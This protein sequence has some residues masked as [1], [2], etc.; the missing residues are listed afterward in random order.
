[1]TDSRHLRALI[2]DDEP[3]ARRG[4]RV[5][6]VL[7][8]GF[9]IVGE[10]ASGRA[11]V[12][13][14]RRLS[15][16]VV[17]LDVQMPE[18]S[19]FDVVE[20]VGLGQMPITVFITAYD[21][22]ALRAFEAHAVDYL[23]KPIDP[24]RFRHTAERVRELAKTGHTPQRLILRDGSRVVVLGLEQI[25]WVEADGD[26]V[27]VY[28]G[29]RGHLVRHTIGALEKRL[30]ATQ[31]VRIHRS[32]IVNVARVRELRPSGDRGFQVVLCDGT[33]LRM[34]RAYRDRLRHFTGPD[35]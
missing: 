8:G 28:A 35:E 13:D 1:M 20:A 23:L 10:S 19:G 3:L 4:I 16:D 7:A 24:A 2:V 30:D 21:V 9:E 25:D 12:A 26:Y 11:A 31:F 29:G 32:T 18:M 14:I 33:R 15:P 17:F 22:Y 5:H 27:R 6:L 34:S